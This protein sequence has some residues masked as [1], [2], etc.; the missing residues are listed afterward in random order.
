MPHSHKIIIIGGGICGLTAATTA[1]RLGMNTLILTGQVLGGHLVSI[2]KV[3]GFPGHPEGIPGF[4]LCPATEEAAAEA[5]AEFVAEDAT[6]LEETADGW[7]VS[8]DNDDYTAP[9]VILA[10]GTSLKHLGVP[11][12]QEYFGKGV[13][14]CA[15]CDAPMLK[16]KQVAVIGGGDS[17]LQEALTLIPVCSKVT[18]ITDGGGLTG[19]AAYVRQIEEASN[20]EIKTGAAVKEIIGDGAVTGVKI[21]TGGFE[22][23]LAVDSVF[24]FIGM[25][26]ASAIVPD[27][28]KDA[29]GFVITDASLRT[30]KP[31]L[32]AAGTIRAGA[33]FRAASAGGEGAAAVMGVWGHFAPSN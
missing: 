17:A 22:E 32:Y 10:M 2:E 6:A 21:S 4:D 7:K 20:V 19:Q 25:E 5:G 12:E 3:D 33:A 30:A 13:S 16:G 9:A 14:H 15:S 29:A 18:I 1:A 23:T 11:G 27:E 26:P 28:L 31:G 8:C 24:V